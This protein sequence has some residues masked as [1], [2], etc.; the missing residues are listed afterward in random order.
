VGR[1]DDYSKSTAESSRR[2]AD[3]QVFSP[4]RDEFDALINR[5]LFPEMGVIYHKFKSSTPNTTDNALLVKI[6]ATAEKTG[7]ITPRIARNVMQ[8]ILGEALPD[9]PADFPA[10]VPFSLTM[11]QA[12]KNMADPAEPGQQVTALKALGIVFGDNGMDLDIDD[13]TDELTIAK[14]LLGLQKSVEELWKKSRED[15]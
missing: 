5:F 8:Q 7:G 3:E 6:L 9:F 4:E 1:S 10:D 14:K 11:A 12:V 13:D 2:L 15:A